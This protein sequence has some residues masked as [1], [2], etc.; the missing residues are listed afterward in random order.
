MNSIIIEYRK[1]IKQLYAWHKRSKCGRFRAQCM[2]EVAQLKLSIAAIRY[3][4]SWGRGK[5]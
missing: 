2:L 1:Q 4:Q 3:A 5:A